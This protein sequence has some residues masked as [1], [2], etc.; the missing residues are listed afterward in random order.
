MP[1]AMNRTLP[2]P[3]ARNPAANRASVPGSGTAAAVPSAA[4]P[5][6]PCE[7]R[8]AAE[9]RHVR[10]C[11]FNSAERH[12]ETPPREGD[13]CWDFQNTAASGWPN[14]INWPLFALG[15][16]MAV[17]GFVHALGCRTAC[18]SQRTSDHRGA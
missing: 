17:A 4:L 14:L 2:S 12:R 11:V 6:L 1:L 8:G 18:P 16:A 10:G 7:S 5:A 13:F 15:E 9:R 3:S